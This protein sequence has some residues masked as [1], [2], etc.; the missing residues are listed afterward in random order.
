MAWIAVPGLS[1]KVYVPDDTG[2]VKKKHP[3]KA[4]F[5]CQWCDENR[6]QVCRCG[7]AAT[8]EAGSTPCCTRPL[9]ADPAET[10]RRQQS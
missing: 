2:Q 5:A 8:G 6:C 4:C 9:L 1:G 3:C 10:N 7:S